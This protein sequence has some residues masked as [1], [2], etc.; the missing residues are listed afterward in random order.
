[1]FG[2]DASRA[3]LRRAR[4]EDIPALLDSTAES[5][6]GHLLRPDS[7]SILKVLAS[8]LEDSSV[9]QESY[10][11]C[12]ISYISRS[13]VNDEQEFVEG[14]YET[15]C[16]PRRTFVPIDIAIIGTCGHY[17]SPVAQGIAREETG[18]IRE[19]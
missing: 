13:G 5:H 1:L 14:R 16:H 7:E 18:Q 6:P 2:I 9:S 19:V 17:R 10:N 12:E 3:H 8:R 15:D 4:V 11:V